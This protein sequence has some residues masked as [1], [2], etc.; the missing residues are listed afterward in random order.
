MT[1]QK[2][3]QLRLSNADLRD[4]SQ[5][6]GYRARRIDQ[7]VKRIQV[8]LSDPFLGLGKGEYDFKHSDEEFL[9][10]LCE[11]VGLGIEAYENEIAGLRREL[12]ERRQ[13][14]KSYVFV[15][16]GFQRTS[17]PVFALALSESR[18]RILLDADTRVLPMDQQVSRV[19][20]MVREHF[21]ACK[22]RLGIWGNIRR[23]LFVYGE[24]EQ[25]VLSPGGVIVREAVNEAAGSAK[26]LCEG[27]II[28]GLI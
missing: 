19:Q 10:A 14:F 3:L 26:L 5:M 27:K 17:E 18:R 6:M 20:K 21:E 4:I 22:G 8:L 13:A 25:L 23:Y 16:T 11:L 9:R 7:C 15:D 12:D 1:L 24:N 2:E 28:S